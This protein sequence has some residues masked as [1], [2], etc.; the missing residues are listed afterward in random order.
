[1]YRLIPKIYFPFPTVYVLNIYCNFKFCFIR[2]EKLLVKYKSDTNSFDNAAAKPN[3]IG[4][5]VNT[6]LYTGYRNIYIVICL[7][8]QYQHISIAQN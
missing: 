8:M 7:F 1:M 3:G 5:R 6:E 2:K 4:P